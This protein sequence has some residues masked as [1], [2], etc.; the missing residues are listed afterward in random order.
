MLL[1]CL[2]VLGTAT[3]AWLVISVRPEVSGMALNIGANG[4]L[5]IALLSAD[6]YVNTDLIKSNVGD[7][8]EV[9]S[10]EEANQTW[11][12]VIDLSS[13]TYGLDQ[14]QLLPAMLSVSGVGNTAKVDDGLLRVPAFG[15]DGRIINLDTGAV[16]GA[17]TGS[18]F[19]CDTTHIGYGVRGVGSTS[20]IPAQQKAVMAARSA[21]PTYSTMARQAATAVLQSNGQILL[22]VHIRHNASASAVFSDADVQQLL[23]LARG[24]Q[25]ALTYIDT[26]VRYGVA[27]MAAAQVDDQSQFDM[28]YRLVMDRTVPLAALLQRL[29]MNL[30]EDVTQWITELA[31]EMV[32]ADTIVSGCEQLTGGVYPWAVIGPVAENLADVSKVYV[33]S[34]A[35]TAGTILADGAIITLM[36]GSGLFTFIA[37]YTDDYQALA[38]GF[39]G[40]PASATLT[41]KARTDKEMGRMTR[42]SGMVNALGTITDAELNAPIDDLYGYAVDLAFRTNAAD[43]FLQLQTSPTQRIYQ[44]ATVAETMGGGSY[45]VFYSS[46]P[47]EERLVELLDAVRVTFIDGAGN[48]LA[49]AKLNTSNFDLLDDGV[50]APLYLYDFTCEGSV[51]TIGQRQ[52]DPGTIIALPQNIPT[53]VTAVV[54]LD[55]DRVDNSLAAI[56]GRSV[57]GTLNLQFSSSADLLPAGYSK[58]EDATGLPV[59]QGGHIL[60]RGPAAQILPSPQSV[61]SIS[62][63]P[64]LNALVSERGQMPENYYVLTQNGQPWARAYTLM[65]PMT[66]SDGEPYEI[67]LVGY[68]YNAILAPADCSGLF[69]DL[70]GV[71]A[72]TGLDKLN[73]SNTT[74]MTDMF[75]GCAGLTELDI[76]AWDMRRVKA[77]DNLFYGCEAL[78]SLTLPASLTVI[79]ENATEGCFSLMDV[80]YL[81]TE[82][83]WARVTVGQGNIPLDSA[84][85]HLGPRPDQQPQDPTL[86]P[87]ELVDSGTAGNL[88]WKFYDSGLL[89][90][91]GQGSMSN[92]N[93]SYDSPWYGHRNEITR[94]EIES[95]VTSIGDEAFFDYYRLTSVTIPDSV[96]SIGDGAFSGCYRLTAITV[97]E[98]NPF[99]AD[100]D[101]VLFSKD[102]KTLAQYP[103]GKS[104]NTYAIPSGVTGIRKYA[105]YNC[106]SLTSMTIP[107]SVTSIGNYA[108]TGCYS[109]TSVTIPD[110]MTHIGKEAFYNCV[111]L[112]DVYYSGSQA[113]WN[114][115]SIGADND[116]LTS[117]TIHFSTLDPDE[118]VDSGT[119]GDLTW[120]FYDS[121]L[122]KISGQG[123]MSNYTY[124]DSP[125]YGHRDEITRVEIESGVTSIGNWA[126]GNC[127]LTSVTIPDSVTSIGSNA[128]SNC[129]SLTSVT[130]LGSVTSIGFGVFSGCTSLRSVTIPDSVTSIG[131]WAFYYCDS[132]TDIYYSGSWAKWN[133][134]R[135]GTYNNPLSFATIHI[136]NLDPGELVDS[137]TAG[138]LTWKFYDSGILKISGRGSMSNYNFSYDSPWSRYSNQITRVEIESG[139]TSIGQKAFS[140]Y[141]S[142]TSVTIPDS[143]T[144]IGELAFYRCPLK[145]VTIPDS[146]TSIGSWAFYECSSLTDVYYSGSQAQW[147]T[148]SIGS[149]NKPLTSATKHFNS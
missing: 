13:E 9:R 79:G 137:G 80:Y 26:G 29:P 41:L 35:Y 93:F 52:D 7:S 62:L 48:L 88:T 32:K 49:Q 98:D 118:P 47:D 92:Y 40:A 33:G 148:V 39:D 133:T 23:A 85:I 86:D 78:A 65:D 36:P 117:A 105:F 140:S 25:T 141:S 50:R 51:M 20:A 112:T 135:I 144:S 134:V 64:N 87:G 71:T 18:E 108:F 6:T 129:N 138:N 97:H 102:G 110:S 94:V 104:G 116:P 8:L 72:I 146:V 145:Y 130:I 70:S 61:T 101:G 54:W 132:L 81:G 82:S 16:T 68:E 103:A 114:T 139:V 38:S 121:G 30:P 11:G 66:Y 142:L 127:K 83:Q 22:N 122:L 10:A 111:R 107:D 46:L 77:T 59:E 143:V 100:V 120:E 55:G 17:Y 1:V 115:V 76:S 149:N 63:Y 58:L 109:L 89:K 99:Y 19:L 90:I 123:S 15:S 14:I 4:G 131:D 56:F 119:A 84:A 43:S 67:F 60:S 45:M 57:T 91:S 24:A 136:F 74:D 34:S 69:A 125:W 113:Q 3:Y 2:T 28:I 126:F 96:T 42:F 106:H 75:S 124:D 95:G 147:K 53:I 27:A 37:D 21:L 12:N 128:F 31:A 73:V 44:D 5:E